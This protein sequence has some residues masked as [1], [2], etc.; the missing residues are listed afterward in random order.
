MYRCSAPGFAD[1]WDDPAQ[2]ENAAHGLVLGGLP[3][4][5]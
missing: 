5:D 1:G 4:D 2:Y 3:D